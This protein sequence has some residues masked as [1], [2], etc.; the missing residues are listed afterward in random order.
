VRYHI[1]L[2]RSSMIA[3]EVALGEVIALQATDSES[4]GIDLPLGV[5][6]NGQ[7]RCFGR[8]DRLGHLGLFA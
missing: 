4:T 3:Q 7:R 5:E 1:R 8:V 2:L 6:T